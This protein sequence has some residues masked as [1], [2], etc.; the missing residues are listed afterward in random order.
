[1][2]RVEKHL[3]PQS[4]NGAILEGSRSKVVGQPRVEAELLVSRTDGSGSS[5]LFSMF[6]SLQIVHIL[7]PLLQLRTVESEKWVS[8]DHVR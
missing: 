4:L 7:P 6:Y 3:A 1:M 5:L 8:G 2:I